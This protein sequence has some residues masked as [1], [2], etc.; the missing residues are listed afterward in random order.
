MRNNVLK[1]LNQRTRDYH[2]R[3]VGGEELELEL[4]RQKSLAAFLTLDPK[5]IWEH[6]HAMIRVSPA[7]CSAAHTP[8]ILTNDLH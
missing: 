2:F 4:S 3:C 8:G 6:R 1:Y 5:P 7:A